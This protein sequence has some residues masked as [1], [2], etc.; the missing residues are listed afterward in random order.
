MAC[1]TKKVTFSSDFK[2]CFEFLC[3]DIAEGR[4]WHNM[5]YKSLVSSNCAEVLQHV[6]RVKSEKVI[7]T[8]DQDEKP[9][10]ITKI[11]KQMYHI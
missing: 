4:F 10:Y 11:L 7:L 1:D 9:N 8:K 3:I 6:Q 2:S 5:H